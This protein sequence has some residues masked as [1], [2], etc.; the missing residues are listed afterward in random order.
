MFK[1]FGEKL[2]LGLL[3]I[4]G[5]ALIFAVTLLLVGVAKAIPFVLVA[6]VVAYALGSLMYRKGLRLD[7]D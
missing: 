6:L 2:G 3:G 4:L 7:R 1:N 5:T